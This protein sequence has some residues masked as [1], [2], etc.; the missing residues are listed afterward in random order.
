MAWQWITLEGAFPT[1]INT[2]SEWVRLRQGECT[3]ID[4]A[5]FDSFGVLR[6]GTAPVASPNS[7]ALFFVPVDGSD[8]SGDGCKYFYS[9]NRWWKVSLTPVIDGDPESLYRLEYTVLQNGSAPEPWTSEGH[10]DF[11]DDGNGPITLV[12]PS[13]NG[14]I[15]VF[16]ENAGYVLSN[17]AGDDDD[18]QK[19]AA[20]Y[21]IGATLSK[22]AYANSVINGYAA[23][24]WD[25]AGAHGLRH[26]LW[27]GGDEVIELSRLVRKYSEAQTGDVLLSCNWGQTLV[28][29]RDIVYDMDNRRIYRYSGNA[30]ATL[31]SRP[32]SMTFFSPFA[33]KKLAVCTTGGTGEF[34]LAIESG[35]AENRLAIQRSSKFIVSASTENRFRHTWLLE[36]PIQ[37]RVFRV[38]V[39]GLK[40]DI[41]IYQIDA[42][43]DPASDPD[44]KDGTT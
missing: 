2:E 42:L 12:I 16:K 7:R 10:I 31:I 40:G 32:Y 26:F 38:R 21:S 24:A 17:C 14:K 8:V 35:Q 29:A 1:S 11:N 19:S 36:A 23:V 22:P 9:Y 37:T 43:I 39:E 28:I 18:F 34:T 33:V 44:A 4:Q 15:F 6:Y 30:Y 5:K 25:G 20:N 3:D 13:G 41:G 27:A